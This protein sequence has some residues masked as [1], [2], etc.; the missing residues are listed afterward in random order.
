[1]TTGVRKGHDIEVAIV[2]A[3]ISGVYAG[4]RLLGS[5]QAKSVT[6]FEQ[7]KRVGGRLLSLQP[8]GLP[9]V[10]CELGGMR[11]TSNQPNVVRADR[12]AQARDS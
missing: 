7:S 4:W 6:I 2:G 8:P 11:Y 12:G 10:W 5:G 1:M 9:D 3:G